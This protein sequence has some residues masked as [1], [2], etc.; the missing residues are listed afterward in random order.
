MENIWNELI[1]EIKKYNLEANYISYSKS[2]NIDLKD[3]KL[4]GIP[5]F[6]KW[7]EF[8]IYKDI[9]NCDYREWIKFQL[10]TQINLNDIRS[11]LLPNHWILQFFINPFNDQYGTEWWWNN[12]DNNL[13]FQVIYH[14]DI[15][16]PQQKTE[17]LINTFSQ[18]ERDYNYLCN[19]LQLPIKINFS[20]TDDDPIQYESLEHEK[21]FNNNTNIDNYN[22]KCEDLFYYL[23]RGDQYLNN[24]HTGNKILWN[25]DSRLNWDLRE[26]EWEKFKNYILLLQLELCSTDDSGNALFDNHDSTLHFFISKE[27]LKNLNFDNVM[28]TFSCT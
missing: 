16:L 1:N 7:K 28:Y 14:P 3:S 2:D 17:N 10:L 21:I 24:N 20:H 15:S 12:Y 27:D 13:E 8:P 6:P 23:E 25:H 22:T 19:H 4:W 18:E 26:N 11:E 5:Y 9:R